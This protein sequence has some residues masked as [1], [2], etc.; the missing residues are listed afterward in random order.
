MALGFHLWAAGFPMLVLRKAAIPSA[1]L[2]SG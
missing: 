1:K 2:M